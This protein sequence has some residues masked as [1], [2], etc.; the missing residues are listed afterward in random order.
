[1]KKIT[2]IISLIMLLTFTSN[3]KKKQD[4]FTM[5]KGDALVIFLTQSPSANEVYNVY[6][7]SDS[8]YVLLTKEAPIRAVLSGDEARA[9]LGNDWGVISKA[10][11]SE[12]ETAVVRAIRSNTFRGSMLTLMSNSAAKIAGRWFEDSNITIGNSYTYKIIFETMSGS[13]TDSLIKTVKALELIPNAPTSLELTAGNKQIH[14]EWKYPKWKADFSDLGFRY[15]VYR[16]EGLG[17]FK[18][19]NKNILIRDD[20]S[21]P[22]YDDIWL[23]DGTKYSYKVTI[24]DLVGNESA[25]SNI[26]EVVLKDKTPPAIVNG[27]MAEAFKDGMRL[28]WNMNRELDTKGY[29]IYRA[30]SLSGPFKKINKNLVMAD[31]PFYNDT[32]IATKT[33]YFFSISAVDTAGNEGD[34]SNGKSTY[35]KDNFPPDAPTNLTYKIVNNKVE[36]SWKNA[37]AKDITGYNVYKSERPTGMKSRITLTPFKGNKYVDGGEAD[38]G[39]GYGAKFYYSVTAQDSSRNESDSLNIIVYVPDNTAPF[40][41]KNFVVKTEGSHVSVNCGMS[42]S[43]DAETYI[44]SRALVGKKEAK[45]K[46][47][48]KAPFYYSDTTIVKGE[49]Y[50]YL[51]S[52]I[53]TAGNVS[54][55]SVQDTVMFEDFSP[56]PAPRNVKARLV[57][58]KVELKW[59]KS[60]DFD[61]V[62]YN[63][64]R[65]NHISGT[66]KKINSKVITVTKFT[67]NG[68]SKKYYY[69]IKSIDTSG[70]ESKYDETVSPK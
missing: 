60:V 4:F 58:G 48:K 46:E 26:V 34:L 59:V 44:L 52:V 66:F 55:T 39:F 37:K 2:L 45:L 31:K 62:G 50:V 43:L 69:R 8:G 10:V 42:P 23:S 51:V 36:L 16:K 29:N 30:E 53:D 5:V 15:N 22:D 6:R 21:T 38:K 67:D 11:D 64:Y 18:K 13:V 41:P 35:L 7:K 24:L 47:F 25:A 49:S 3:A 17:E 68:G 32:T 9:I 61:M 65:S 70:N 12:S 28:S 20:S 63:I 1:M 33:Q 14:L 40:P 27:V 57:K 56:P 54:K 19:I